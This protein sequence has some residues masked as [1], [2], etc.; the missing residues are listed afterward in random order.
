MEIIVAFIAML[1]LVAVVFGI[2]QAFC[3]GINATFS[4]VPVLAIGIV[5][6]ISC[7]IWFGGYLYGLP[8]AEEKTDDNQT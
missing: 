3:V 2:G 8:D 6:L 7:G 4:D 5:V 1:G